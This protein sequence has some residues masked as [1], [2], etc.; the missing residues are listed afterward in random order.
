M[1]LFAAWSAKKFITKEDI[2]PGQR[3][4][5]WRPKDGI[6]I[7]TDAKDLEKSTEGLATAEVAFTVLFEFEN[8]V[9]FKI[10]EKLT[11]NE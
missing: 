11:S 10:C 8:V 6:A 1:N 2:L 5:M 4:N 3:L 7:I 9:R